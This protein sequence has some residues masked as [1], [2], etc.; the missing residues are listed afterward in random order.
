V[1]GLGR[2][3]VVDEAPDLV[4][5]LLRDEAGQHAAGEADRHERDFMSAPFV[6]RPDQEAEHDRAADRELAAGCAWRRRR[7]RAR[8]SAVRADAL[9]D[10]VDLLAGL[11]LTS[12][13]LPSAST[14]SPSS[15]RV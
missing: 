2:L 9:L 13:F 4:E 3:D 1:L 8:C 7:P 5:D 10:L 11:P 6:M 12:V 15:I 14:V